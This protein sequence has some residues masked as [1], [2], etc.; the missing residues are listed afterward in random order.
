MFLDILYMYQAQASSSI[1]SQ[2][3]PDL[4]II[5]LTV[6]SQTNPGAVLESQLPPQQQQQ[7]Q[8]STCPLSHLTLIYMYTFEAFSVICNIFCM[9]L[10]LFSNHQNS[11]HSFRH[12]KV[13]VTCTE[14][15]KRQIQYN[16]KPLKNLY[17]TL[18]KCYLWT[19]PRNQALTLLPISITF[20]PHFIPSDL[21]G[22]VI[23]LRDCPEKRRHES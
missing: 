5:S 1:S 21:N 10:S 13:K 20:A 23:T 14:P 9:S 4:F 6:L 18:S 2:Q 16:L 22:V 15:P 3:S 8:N 19:T 12:F 7:Q 17:T 11:G